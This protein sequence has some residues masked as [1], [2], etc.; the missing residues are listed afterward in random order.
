LLVLALLGLVGRDLTL[1]PPPP[2]IDEEDEQVVELPIDPEPRLAITFQPNSMKFGLTTRSRKGD[3]S[4]VK[5]LTFSDIGASNSA[6]VRIDGK[7]YLFGRSWGDDEAAF[8]PGQWQAAETPLGEDIGG[9]KREG[10]R[11]AWAYKKPPVVVTQ[12]VEIIAGPDPAEGGKRLLDTCL[13]RYH[14]ENRDDRPHE[15]GLRFLLDTFIGSNDGVPFSIPGKNAT[16][17]KTQADFNR[18]ADVPDYVEALEVPDLQNPGTVA[19]LTLRVGRGLEAPERLSLTHYVYSFEV[20]RVDGELRA[21]MWDV[22]MQDMGWDSAAVLY[23]ADRALPPGEAREVGFAYGLGKVTSTAGG[24]LA[25]TSGGDFVV[26]GEF[27]IIA[28]VNDPV[29]EQTVRLVLPSGLEHVLGEE[30]QAVPAPKG[31]VRY[32]L[33]TW[34]VKARRSGRFALRVQ[35]SSGTAQTERVT[36]RKPGA[37]FD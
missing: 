25:L 1:P 37:L 29:P 12:T 23:W 36:I 21:R 32:S 5:R 26:G 8:A 7:P 9:R 14:I 16:L 34:K 3:S 24:K 35:S 4:P 20:Q 33:V 28:Y 2:I 31:D 27:T 30:T 6:C 15:V 11:S 17:C 19:R 13:V 22:P 10:L 18:P